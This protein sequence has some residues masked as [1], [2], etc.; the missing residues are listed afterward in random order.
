MVAPSDEE[1][2]EIFGKLQEESWNYL[3]A[4]KFG[5]IDSVAAIR[6]NVKNFE[7][8][9]GPVFGTLQSLTNLR[10]ILRM[11]KSD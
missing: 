11:I 7:M 6:T 2:K 1:A 10:H 4:I 8:F 5:D 3:P 9:H